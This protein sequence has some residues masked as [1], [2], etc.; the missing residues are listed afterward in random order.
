MKAFITGGTGFIGSHLI[1]LL[2][3]RDY[4][5][6]TIATDPMFL[7][8]L[9]SPNLEVILDDLNH[10]NDWPTVLDDVDIVFHLA[11]ITR[12]RQPEDYYLGNFQA[13]RKF[14]AMCKEHGKNV[15]RFVYV[16]SLAAT[17]PCCSGQ[18]VNESTAYHPVSHYGKSKM[19]A[20]LE[21]LSVR[22]DF[23]VTIVRPSAVYGPRDRDM[24]K[25]FQ[26][27]L[28]GI[29]PIIGFRK[30]YL[31][32]IHVEDLINGILLAGEKSSAE[33]QI[34]FLGSTESY[35]N[36]QIGLA[37][38]QAVSR[39]PVR[40]RVPHALIY[41]VGALAQVAGLLSGRQIFFNI[42]KAREAVQTAWNCSIDKA[43][44]ILGFYPRVSLA[45]G[46]QA[47]YQ[48]YRQNRWL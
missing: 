22:K 3:N 25:Y 5:V 23:P 16:S 31:N 21:V 1:E 27:I 40:V 33:D 24:Y 17:G 11:G 12:A 47:T 26:L 45:D 2:L 19:M 44:Q 34:F 4:A 18:A 30:K 10:F 46:M 20:E 28:K 38:A 35:T 41:M 39:Y 42:Q 36:E 8:K 43:Q 48:W 32:L 9:K 13:T 29:H 14:V 37:I 15:K 7:E 6:R